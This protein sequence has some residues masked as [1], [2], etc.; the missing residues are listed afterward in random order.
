M[1]TMF[2]VALLVRDFQNFVHEHTGFCSTSRLQKIF[3]GAGLATPGC[4]RAE[5][6]QLGER[7]LRD[8]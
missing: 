6:V 2:L 7:V 5:P 8:V 4:S 3:G 1:S